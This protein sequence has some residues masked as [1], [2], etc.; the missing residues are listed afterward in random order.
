[1]SDDGSPFEMGQIDPENVRQ[2]D[3]MGLGKKE[4]PTYTTM[5]LTPE[6]TA[7]QNKSVRLMSHYSLEVQKGQ[8]LEN[9]INLADD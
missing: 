6:E 3:E 1:M 8:S 5:I 7:L 4:S 2:S 9:I